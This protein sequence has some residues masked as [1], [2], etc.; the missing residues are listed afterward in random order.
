MQSFIANITHNTVLVTNV[1][2]YSYKHK[3]LTKVYMKWNEH[4]SPATVAV[5]RL[6]PARRVRSV[7]QKPSPEKRRV[8]TNGVE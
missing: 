2:I 3:L 7:C 4:S 1:K 8:V 6:F 5:R